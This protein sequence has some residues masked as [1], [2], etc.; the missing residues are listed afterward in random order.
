MIK[1]I[2]IAPLKKDFQRII[3]FD[4]IHPAS[5]IIVFVTKSDTKKGTKNYKFIETSLKKLREYCQLTKIQFNMQVI[6]C[7]SKHSFLEVIMDFARVILIEYQPDSTY[8]LNLGDNS[9]LMNISLLQAA[10]IVQSIYDNDFRIFVEEIYQDQEII[11][12]KRIVKSFENLV[13]EPV[14]LVLLNCVINGKNL[15]EIKSLL[16]ISLGSVS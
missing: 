9:L 14:S 11:F 5:K 6:D 10:Q 3:D 7:K 15:E 4:R 13:S 1:Q 12:E 8:L 2:Q 16:N